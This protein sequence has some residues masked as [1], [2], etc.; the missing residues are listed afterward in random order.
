MFYTD[1][2]KRIKQKKTIK[3]HDYKFLLI[4]SLIYI[5]PLGLEA[6]TLSNK[7]NIN[8]KAGSSLFYYIIFYVLF[9]KLILKYKISNHHIFSLIIIIAC[10]YY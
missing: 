8:F 4:L 9:S 1:W 2:K 5:I 6:F 3:H 10:Q 7:I